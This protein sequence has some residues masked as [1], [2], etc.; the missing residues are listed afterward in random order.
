M[1]F[2]GYTDFDDCVRQNQ[3]ARDPEA[4]CATI[5]SKVEGETQ[6]GAQMLSQA[7]LL[8]K[9]VIA[10][11]RDSSGSTEHHHKNARRQGKRSGVFDVPD[12]TAKLLG[13]KTGKAP[14]KVN[15]RGVPF[16]S[17]RTLERAASAT[18]DVITKHDTPNSPH[19]EH[20]PRYGQGVSDDEGIARTAFRQQNLAD[21][22]DEVGM[23]HYASLL[24]TADPADIT[25]EN[26]QEAAM[27]Y[28]LAGKALGRRQRG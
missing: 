25:P 16:G 27:V 8:V 11:H 18:K 3:Q 19:K 6:K 24:R 12:V 22:L 5:K 17:T 28:F 23:S 9:G 13:Y 20:D 14:F 15:A 26:L 21:Q 4:Y 10:K 7:S 1:P 2:A